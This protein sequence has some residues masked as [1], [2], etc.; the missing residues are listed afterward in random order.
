MRRR[1]IGSLLGDGAEVARVNSVGFAP[2]ILV[3]RRRPIGSLL[4]G[5]AGGAAVS[6]RG[7]SPRYV[8]PNDIGPERAE[9]RSWP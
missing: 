1:P 9:D 2:A 4:G 6:S 7:R 3:R 5:G 8:A